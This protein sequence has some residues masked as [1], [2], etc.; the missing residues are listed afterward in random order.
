MPI[1]IPKPNL[2]SAQRLTPFDMTKI[3][4]GN[5]GLQSDPKAQTH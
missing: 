3:H 1:N 2:E 4:F 5:H